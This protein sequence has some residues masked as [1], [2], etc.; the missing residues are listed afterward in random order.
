MTA[1]KSTL[2]R[3]TC[4]SNGIVRPNP[5][6]QSI[7]RGAYLC[8]DPACWQQAAQQPALFARALRTT[9]KTLD[10]ETL[11]QEAVVLETRT[12]VKDI[13]APVTAEGN[14]Q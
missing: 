10:R 11:E 4:D 6:G 12:G 2:T 9:V 5:P 13:S 1:D 3:L 7:G 8:S 14:R